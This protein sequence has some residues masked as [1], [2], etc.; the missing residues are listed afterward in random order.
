M[1]PERVERVLT[2]HGLH[3]LEFEEGSTP[4]AA[5]AAEKIGVRVGQIAKSILMKGKDD[6]YRLFILAGDSKISS[7]K[8]KR[9]AG[10]KHRMSTTEETEE[11][12]GYRPGGV[13]P[14]AL[15]DEVEVYIDEELSRYDTIYPAAGNDATGV[16]VRYETLRDITGAEECSVAH[17]PEAAE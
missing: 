2:A 7:G 15:P 6:R 11:V 1:I 17:V 12:T 8:V 14:F 3:A 9:L 13:C 4:T 10:V 16:P 5:T